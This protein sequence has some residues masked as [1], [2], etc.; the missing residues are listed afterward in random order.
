MSVTP[1]IPAQPAIPLAPD[2]L[3]AYEAL[4]KQYESAIEN[5][6]DDKLLTSLNASQLAVANVIVLN[7][8]AIIEQNSTAFAAVLKQLNTT[9]TGLTALQAQINKIASDIKVYAGILGGITKVLSM[10]PGI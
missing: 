8:Q 1:V 4:Y 3:A 9:N 2:V 10:V 6:A 7:N 5:T